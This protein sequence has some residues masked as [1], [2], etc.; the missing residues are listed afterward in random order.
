MS[1]DDS[2]S[3]KSVVKKSEIEEFIVFDN[4]I[5][6]ENIIFKHLL[7]KWDSH[8]ILESSFLEFMVDKIV[9]YVFKHED[10]S[11]DEKIL[12]KHNIKVK[13]LFSRAARRF[14]KI[15]KNEETGKTSISGESGELI[16]FLLLE[17][18]NIVQ[19]VNKMLYKLNFNKHVEGMD[20]IHIQIK[21]GKIIL[22]FGESKMYEEF[23]H[24]LADAIKSLESFTMEKEEDE[25]EIIST[26]MD[27]P[28][29]D[30]HVNE[31][32]DILLPYSNTTPKYKKRYAVLLGFNWKKLENISEIN[33]SS[34]FS[35]MLQDVHQ[36]FNP[37]IESKIRN[38]EINEKDFD[39]YLMPLQNVDDFRKKF[40]EELTN[41]K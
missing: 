32:R 28:K 33:S 17:S 36:I 5:D 12:Q 9:H 38:S 31:I 10:Y 3:K 29:F 7:I 15:T 39:F 26:H 27:D 21:N 40:N 25:F 20:A 30:D 22:Y 4:F 2:I 19:L 11:K 6:K 37:K 18:Q 13:K 34:N 1:W 14:I 35:K 16:L 41:G 8:E 24:G 23:S